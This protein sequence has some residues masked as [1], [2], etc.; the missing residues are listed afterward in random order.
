M[1]ASAEEYENQLIQR[2]QDMH[3]SVNAVE[4][5]GLNNAYGNDAGDIYGAYNPLTRNL[6][7]N[8]SLSQDLR[9]STLEHELTHALQ[10]NDLSV[11]RKEY[12]AYLVSEPRNFIRTIPGNIGSGISQSVKSYNRQRRFKDQNSS[13]VT[14]NGAIVKAIRDPRGGR[15]LQ[16][17]R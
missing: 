8:S 5:G 2:A 9:V 3:I 11:W 10:P 14:G 17:S 6:M 16:I 13:W 7:L 15:M 12:E 4:G 1:Y